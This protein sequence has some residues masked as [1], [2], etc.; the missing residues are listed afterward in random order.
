MPQSP[1]PTKTSTE[2]TGRRNNPRFF[3]AKKSQFLIKIYELSNMNKK[4]ITNMHQP[5]LMFR[6]NHW[7]T[8]I[9]L[10]SSLPVLLLNP[11]HNPEFSPA[12]KWVSLP[13]DPSFEVFKQ[14]FHG[15]YY[16][17]LPEIIWD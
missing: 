7:C 11:N 2:K 1:K 4:V 15:Y 8:K 9:K 13:D 17:A 14:I 16:Y 12:Y 6:C 5:D 3:F 10:L